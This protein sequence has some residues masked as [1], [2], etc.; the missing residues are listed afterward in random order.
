MKSY[1]INFSLY[2][3][4]FICALGIML[5]TIPVQSIGID[6]Q[7]NK[8]FRNGDEGQSKS[9][10]TAQVDRALLRMDRSVTSAA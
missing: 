2:L 6:M 4:E 8:T 5:A 3:M 9:K 7:Q 1:R 10:A